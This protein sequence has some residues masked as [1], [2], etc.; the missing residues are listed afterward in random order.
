[1]IYREAADNEGQLCT[2]WVC[3]M[4]AGEGGFKK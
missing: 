2:F 3:P 4:E 1:M